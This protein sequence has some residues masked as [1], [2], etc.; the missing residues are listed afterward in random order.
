[1]DQDQTYW[2][3]CVVCI[4]CFSKECVRMC[5]V[6]KFESCVAVE[7]RSTNGGYMYRERKGPNDMMTENIKIKRRRSTT[8]T[9]SLAY[10][11]NGSC[12]YSHWV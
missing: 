3:R 8:T 1:M 5:L 11:Y 6:H 4:C 2:Q 12:A 7:G 9:N 10:L